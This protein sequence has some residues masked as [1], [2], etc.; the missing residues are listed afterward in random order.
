MVVGTAPPTRCGLA[1]YTANSSRALHEAGVK[2]AILKV[3]PTCG[4]GEFDDEFVA[5]IWNGDGVDDAYT[6][7]RS[8]DG[9]DSVLFQHEFGI[10]PGVDGD[11][12]LSFLCEV[13]PPVVSVLHT[14]LANPSWRQ[15]SIIEEVAAMSETLVVHGDA[16]KARLLSNH[17]FN[18]ERIVVIPHGATVSDDA[19][20][21]PAETG[22]TTGPHVILTWGLLGPGK[23]IEHVIDAMFLLK[24]AGV[25]AR[26]VV[27]GATHPN[28]L[29]ECG[30]GYRFDLRDRAIE[31]DLQ[32]DI[33]FDDRYRTWDEQR[34]LLG[35]STVIVLPYDSRD[36]A[37]SGVLVEALAAGKP[38]IATAFPHAIELAATGAVDVVAHG[39]PDQ[40]AAAI[41]R[42][43]TDTDH[44]D[45]MADAAR[46]EGAKCDWSEVGRKFADVLESATET[47]KLVL[48]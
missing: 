4:L 8:C 36:Q 7:A 31:L 39:S 3:G 42:V 30:E 10:Y 35:E 47:S 26:Y 17:S 9:Y 2:S 22:T 32:D 18:P 33:V 14:V 23:G 24:D 12:A 13:V 1:T 15:H 28:V 44:R 46:V 27:A 48:R 5:A 29:R 38:V 16:A 43:L 25:D 20:T 21:D 40:L 6:A 19:P 41:E 45:R 37:T 34:K 11:L